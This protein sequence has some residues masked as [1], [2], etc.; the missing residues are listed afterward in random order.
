M[1]RF[2]LIAAPAAPKRRSKWT[3][4]RIASWTLLFASMAAWGWLILARQLP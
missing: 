1:P 2:D 3:A 4:G